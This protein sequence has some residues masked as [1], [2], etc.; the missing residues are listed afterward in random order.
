M[1]ELLHRIKVFVFHRRGADTRYL[2]LRPAQGLEAC[3]GPLQ[4]NLGFGEKLEN[5]VRREVLDDIGLVQPLDLIEL[6]PPA[7]TMLGIEDVVEW[8]FGFHAPL[9]AAPLRLG[10]RWSEFRWAP[11]GSAYPALELD[12]DREALLRLHAHLDAA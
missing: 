12:G 3:W 1:A 7:V 5:A 8:T 9:A 2:L 6:G 10:P 4:G 11:L